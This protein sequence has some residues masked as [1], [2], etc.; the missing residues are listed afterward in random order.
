MLYRNHLRDMRQLSY[1]NSEQA[2]IDWMT[3]FHV[4]FDKQQPKLTKLTP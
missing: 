2:D 4:H 1:I 3:H